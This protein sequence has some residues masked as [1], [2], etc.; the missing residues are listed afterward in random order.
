MAPALQ[1]SV[2]ALRRLAAGATL[3]RWLKVWDK[4]HHLAA[5]APR[6]PRPQAGAH[7]RSA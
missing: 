6:Q 7:H 3:D 2:P 4:T 1:D 5:Q